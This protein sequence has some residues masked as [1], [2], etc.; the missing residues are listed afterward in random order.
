[1]GKE[2]HIVFMYKKKLKN[3]K[4]NELFVKTYSVK[5]LLS[6]TFLSVR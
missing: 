2:T 4:P 1:M 3:C 5:T 6:Y